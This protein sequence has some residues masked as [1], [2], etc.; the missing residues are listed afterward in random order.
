MIVLSLV[1]TLACFV[2][3]FLVNREYKLA[4]ML[5]ATI[6]MSLV[7]L[8]FKGITALMAITFGF[9]ISEVKDYKMH[10][11]RIKGTVIIPYLIL[12]VISFLLAV[13]TSSHLHNLNDFGYFALSEV[14]VKQLALVY[15]FLALRKKDSLIP[16][17][18]VSFGALILMTV[19]GVVNYID[20]S[21][22]LVDTLY[23]DSLT[24]YDFITADRFRVQATFLNP[25]DY[26]YMCVL[27]ALMHLYAFLQRMEGKA[28]L[29]IA[30]T[31]CLFGVITCNCRTILFCYG[32]CALLFAVCLQ[33]EAS[34]KAK[35]VI[36]SFAACMLLVAIFPFA[37]Q[38]FRSILSIF[39]TRSS[40]RGSSLGMRILQLGTVLYYISGRF[41]FFGRG[42][43]FFERDL[44]W[45]NGSLMAADSDLYGLEGIY[46][47]LLLE[48][49]IVGFA[50]YMVM[51]TLILIF[52]IR[53]RRY[54]IKLYAFG[55]SVFALYLLFS[56][57]TGELLSAMP[58]FYILGYVLAN[59]SLRERIIE[60]RQQCE[61]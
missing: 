3:M 40:I 44:G 4:I 9:I 52:L 6:L 13:A 14:M 27:L 50:I 41:L 38:T 32:V 34:R 10:W 47:N 8:P 53:G 54:G 25:F 43:H 18:Y 45:E 33:R 42:V 16:M 11:Q 58:A 59:Q 12:V 39:D 46:L 48:R 29:A 35:I 20:K 15:G 56:F 55:I 36:I 28:M 61:A 23:Q 5:M 30:Q 37:R 21:S 51:M 49:G 17:V 1:L 60:R 2:L 31:C 22:F 7:V 57:M 26:G 24:D 19:S